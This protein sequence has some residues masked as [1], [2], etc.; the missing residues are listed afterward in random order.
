[1]KLYYPIIYTPCGYGYT[2]ESVDFPI[3]YTGQDWDEAMEMMRDLVAHKILDFQKYNHPL[4]DPTDMATVKL[5]DKQTIEMV[6]IDME[7][8]GSFSPQVMVLLRKL[9]GLPEP[10]IIHL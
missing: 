5:K 9:K 7:I 8:Y 3:K 6:E 4:P 1:M 10:Y 2:S